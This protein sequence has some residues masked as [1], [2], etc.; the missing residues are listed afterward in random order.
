MSDD[1]LERLHEVVGQATGLPEETKAEILRQAAALRDE[2]ETDDEVNPTNT[3]HKG[4]DR[5]LA[6]VE[7]L[8]ASHPQITSLIN[9]IAMTLGNTGI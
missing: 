3:Q 4:L 8:E 5:L 2:V 7:G 1:P 6:A 9:R